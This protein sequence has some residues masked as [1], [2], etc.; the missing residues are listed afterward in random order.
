MKLFKVR[1]TPKS[2]RKEEKAEMRREKAE[3]KKRQSYYAKH[4]KLDPFRSKVK[5]IRKSSRRV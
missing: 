1:G 4:G 3:A 5:R 2:M